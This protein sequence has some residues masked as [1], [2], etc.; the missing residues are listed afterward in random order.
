[1]H[2]VGR[3]MEKKS[4]ARIVVTAGLLAAVALVVVLSVQNRSLRAEY[5][6]LYRRASEP[7]A[8]M[9]APTFRAVAISGESVTVGKAAG[10]GRQVLFVFTTTCPYCLASLPSWREIAAA[11]DTVR[12]PSVRTYG[13]SLDSAEATRAYVRQHKLG[14]P[15]VGFPERKLVLLYRARAVPLT[16]VL[17]SAGRVLYSRLGVVDGRALIDSVLAVVR[18]RVQNAPRGAGDSATVARR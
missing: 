17:D 6:A 18:F 10:G 14:F 2:L 3:A 5:A 13:I 11:V 15:V 4:L 8:G 16:M 12:Q 9:Y 7:H 1:M